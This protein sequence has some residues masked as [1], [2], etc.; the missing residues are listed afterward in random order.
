MKKLIQIIV[1]IGLGL[2]A[3]LVLKSCTEPINIS[4]NSTNVRC[5][6]YGEITTETKAHKVTITKSAD[7]Y[8]NKPAETISGAM[9]TITDG[10]S[11]IPLVESITEPG[12]YFTNSNVYGELGKIYT[13]NVSNVDLLGDGVMSS[14]T[15][16]SEMKP[17]GRIDSIETVFNSRWKVW[18]VKA[19]AKDPVET[20]DYYLCKAYINGVL[21]TDSLINYSVADDKFFNGNNT[22]G[23]SVVSFIEKDTIRV[24]TNITLDICGISKDYF[25]FISEVQTLLYGQ[26]PM[27]SGPPANIR[28]NL[29]ND[30][31]GYFTAY[32]VSS[33]SSRVRASSPPN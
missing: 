26:S 19:W 23:L 20:E 33:C 17:V 22:N 12:N 25:K 2:V 32:S 15:A 9:V 24:G 1:K 7:Y 10:V 4:L 21:Y 11:T 27:F 29:S 28:T 5:V 3:V 30:A 14:Y 18:E 8:S 6:I 13:L 16:S 31:I